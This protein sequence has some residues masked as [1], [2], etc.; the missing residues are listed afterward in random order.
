MCLTFDLT[1]GGYISTSLGGAASYRHIQIPAHVVEVFSADERQNKQNSVFMQT[2]SL[3]G[4]NS[5]H[6]GQTLK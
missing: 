2:T 4:W 5:S 3:I 1:S 6:D